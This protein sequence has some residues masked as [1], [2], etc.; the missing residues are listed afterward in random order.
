MIEEVMNASNWQSI[1]SNFLNE[2]YEADFAKYLKYL[3]KNLGD[4]YKKQGFLANEELAFIFDTRR[5]RKAAEQLE[6]EFIQEQLAKLEL[7]SE[8]PVDI[9]FLDLNS[10]VSN[11]QQELKNKYSP[12]VWLTWASGNAKNVS[13]AT[14]VPKLTHSVIDS[15]AFFDTSVVA[16]ET[17]LSTATLKNAAID[18]AV[19]GNQYAPIYQLLELEKNGKKLASEFNNI[20]TD[21][22]ADFAETSE[23]LESWNLGFAAALSEGFP[24]AHFLLKQVYFPLGNTN[25]IS[26][27]YH[28]LCNLVSSSK[29]QAL[30]DF[31]RRN[32][33]ESFK[34]RGSNKFYSDTYF[35]FP[36][37]AAI[38]ITASNHGNASQLNG[39]RG[40][41]LGLYSCQ[42]PVWHSQLKPPVYTSNF[43]YE[44]SKNYEV[45]ETIQYLADFLTRFETLQLSIKDPKRMHWVEKWLES[46]AD[47]VLVYIKTIQTLPA[48]WSTTEGIKLKIEHQVLLDCYRNDKEFLAIQASNNWQSVIAQD[49]AAWLN[50]RLSNADKKFTPTDSH[51]KLWNKLFTANLR[52]EIDIKPLILG[53]VL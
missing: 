10:E 16:K 25:A 42:P 52:E 9:N 39:K 12:A 50:N 3:L 48:G 49:F 47:E 28:L 43:F 7:F 40:G 4:S 44:L 32:S 35:N 51:S 41:R 53:V 5:N 22:L 23:Q 13:F 21:L 34:L 33:N 30:F 14:H 36:N 2:K 15:P 24:K 37:R 31:S 8:H 27:N 29:A 19:R 46:L 6:T 17:Y 20:E 11:K 18:G 26:N 1:V 45:R 38:S